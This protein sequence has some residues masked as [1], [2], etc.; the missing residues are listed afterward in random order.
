MTRL[1]VDT[2]IILDIYLEREPFLGDAGKIFHLGFQK[3]VVLLISALS[4]MNA[5]YSCKKKLSFLNSNSFLSE[6]NRIM[7]I[8]KLDNEIMFNASNSKFKDFEDAV[9]HETAL[10]CKAEC[11]ITR[12]TKDFEKSKLPIFTP[13]QFLNIYY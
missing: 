5:H 2:N 11:I 8:I 4:V 3:E 10:F 13:E 9:Q 12:N 7:S 1:F 6:I